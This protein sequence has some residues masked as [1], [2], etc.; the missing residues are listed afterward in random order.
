[1]D[2]LWDILIWIAKILPRFV[3][4]APDEGGVLT[5]F[6]RAVRVLGEGGHYILIWPVIHEISTVTMTRQVIDVPTQ[7]VMT[8]DKIDVCMNMSVE[9]VISDPYKAIFGVEDFDKCLQ[10]LTGDVAR[11]VVN[12][13]DYK[14]CLELMGG[15]KLEIF[16][17]IDK[18]AE[19]YGVDVL[20]VR[21]PTF[22]TG[23]TIRLIQQ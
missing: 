12:R 15:V 6:G 22:T 1:M 21:V 8:R 23:Y 5:R 2:K 13:K 3:T 19:R 14:T 18:K 11:N 17:M 9:Y 20:E 4:L 16:E 7:D 10:E